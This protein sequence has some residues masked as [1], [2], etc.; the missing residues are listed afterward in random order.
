MKPLITKGMSESWTGSEKKTS[1]VLQEIAGRSMAGVSYQVYRAV[2]FAVLGILITIIESSLSG[3]DEDE[4]DLSE[5]FNEGVKR[6]ALD[7]ALLPLLGNASW[8]AR[9]MILSGIKI[10]EVMMTSSFE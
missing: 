7:Q 6:G 10:N 3:T 5:S 1:D 4:L 2:G 9:L 8:V